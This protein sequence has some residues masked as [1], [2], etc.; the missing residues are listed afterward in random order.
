[1]LHAF[2]ENAQWLWSNQDGVVIR[3]I[4]TYTSEINSKMMKSSTGKDN[5]PEMDDKVIDVNDPKIKE[6]LDRVKRKLKR[7]Y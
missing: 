5:L 6:Q 4:I 7:Q 3:D 1:M 2:P